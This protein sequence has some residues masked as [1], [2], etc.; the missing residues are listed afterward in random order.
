LE[1]IGTVINGILMEISLA[2]MAID[3]HMAVIHVQVGKNIVED[4]LLD[5]G[6]RINIIT[7]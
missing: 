1:N 2:T 3:N 6:S 4:I 7:F 5:G